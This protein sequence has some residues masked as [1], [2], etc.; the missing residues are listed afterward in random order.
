[1]K[2]LACWILSL[3]LTLAVLAC[4]KRPQAITAPIGPP[5][6]EAL[7]QEYVSQGDDL[8]QAMHLYAWRR[9]EAAYTKAYGLA[10]RQ[11]IRDKLALVKLLR[12]T[13]EIDE[14]IACPGLKEDV[15][16]I[17]QDPLDARGQALCDLARGYALGP[18]AAAEQMKRVDPAVL[19]V[20]TSPL[21]AYFFALHSEIIF[22]FCWSAVF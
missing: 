17:C 22:P 2:R 9:A 1:M 15:R 8:F 18:M 14:D 5:V 13:R 20:E 3:V 19:Q 7:I 6:P 11:E 10:A 21:D 12:M 4:H 16:F